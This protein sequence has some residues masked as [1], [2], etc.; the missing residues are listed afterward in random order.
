M[1]EDAGDRQLVIEVVEIDAGI[2]VHGRIV[3]YT[4]RTCCGDL[5]RRQQIEQTT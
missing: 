2:G 1:L 5:W 4:F 3:W